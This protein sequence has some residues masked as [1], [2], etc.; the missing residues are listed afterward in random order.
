V[1]TNLAT[2][3]TLKRLLDH[4]LLSPKEEARLGR[5]AARGEEAARHALVRHNLRLAW[6]F[7]QRCRHKPGV[8][9]NEE[10]LFGEAVAALYRAAGKFR[11]GRGRFCSYAGWHLRD[12]FR[13][14][15]RFAGFRSE[16]RAVDRVKPAVAAWRWLERTGREASD[17]EIAREIG[18]SEE[19]L[20]G[21]LCRAR[22]VSLEEPVGEF[23][24]SL[25]ELVSDGAAGPD[26]TVEENEL[27]LAVRRAMERLEPAL[28]AVIVEGFGFN[29]EAVRRRRMSLR[30]QG[31][32]KRALTELRRMLAGEW[33]EGVESSEANQAAA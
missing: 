20:R 4:P 15:R 14:H 31:E 30:E 22:P 26:R 29:G 2:P 18:W 5:R 21:V 1:N 23:A 11:P 10:D 33:G 24:T 7:V 8:W 32:R 17:W 16:E 27:R 13:R 28:R 12:A 3:T 19:R 6:N 9:G 25:E